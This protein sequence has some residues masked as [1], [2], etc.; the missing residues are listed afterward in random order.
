MRIQQADFDGDILNVFRVISK[1][2]AK[3]FDKN[4]NPRYNLNI[5]RMTGKCNP[6]TMPI[7]DEIVAFWAFCNL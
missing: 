7:K 6:E 4:M 3:R 2:F 5:S 1:D